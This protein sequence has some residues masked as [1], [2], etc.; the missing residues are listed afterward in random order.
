M[1]LEGDTGL[2]YLFITL[3][4]IVTG[5]HL[6]A[7]Y[8]PVHDRLRRC[9]KV[10]LMP[11][12]AGCYAACAQSVSWLVFLG[13][14]FGFIGDVLL[15]FP[16]KKKYFLFGLISFG[17]GHILYSI[18]LLSQLDGKSRALL[19]I[20][21]SVIYLAGAV[22]QILSLR[23]GLSRKMAIASGCYMIVI[24]LMSIS[25]LLFAVSHASFGGWVVFFGSLLFVLS[26]SIL[27][28]IT[29][30]PEKNFSFSYLAVMGTYIAA[31]ACIAFGLAAMGG[32]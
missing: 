32:I 10:L 17:V 11:L 1:N 29:F 7:C 14:A 6:Y 24:S 18:Y 2:S 8:P 4:V 20:I 23:K 16:E 27:S 19:I 30:L 3:F 5:A 9:T 28:T 31:Q 22:F 12:L 15:L 13:I 21:A 25:A 26:D